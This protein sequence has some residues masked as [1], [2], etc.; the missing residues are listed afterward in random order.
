ME[1]IIEKTEPGKIK[2][3]LFKRDFTILIIAQITSILGSSILRFAINLYVLDITGRADIFAL[4]IALSGIPGILFSPIGGAI[5]DRFNRRNLMIIFDFSTSAIIVLLFILLGAGYSSVVMIGLFLATL[6]IIASMYHP[7]VS[8]SVPLLVSGEKLTS[9]N[10]IINGVGA[11][12]NILGPVLGGVLYGFFGI[13]IVIVASA[14]VI[15]MSAIMEIF[16]RIPYNKRESDSGIISTIFRDIKTGAVYVA[17]ENSK[18]LKVL[19]MA[20]A[21]NMLMSPFFFIGTPY[22]LRIVMQSSDTMYGLGMAIAPFATILGALLV[23]VLSK[24]ITLPGIHRYLLICAVALLPMAVALTPNILGLGYFPSFIGYFSFGSVYILIG[25]VLSIF[26]VST[27]QR[28]TPN[29]LLGKV[30]ALV[31]AVSQCVA[32]LGQALYGFLFEQFNDSV[33]IPAL[34]AC[35][36]TVTIAFGVKR[37]LRNC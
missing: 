11:L 30:M 34:M 13:N 31:M 15:F 6:S 36:F 24:K 26:V 16:L 25:T 22:I 5:A 21:L 3:I 19:I 1:N 18:I 20:A 2:D 12:S 32:P 14:I 10:G 29:E 27:I 33:Y 37:A 23:G 35:F 17:K 4:V 7:A 8:A 28:E 9:A